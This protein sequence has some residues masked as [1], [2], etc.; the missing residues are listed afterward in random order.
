MIPMSVRLP[1]MPLDLANRPG[2]YEV[3]HVCLEDQASKRLVE[4]GVSVGCRLRLL[5]PGS[6]CMF[7][8]GECRLSLRGSCCEGILVRELPS[9]I[10]HGS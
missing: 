7:Q 10:G 5:Q 8:I 2:W 9:D 6:P 3:E 4:M 1:T